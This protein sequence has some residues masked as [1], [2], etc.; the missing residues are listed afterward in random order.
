MFLRFKK[1]EA[2]DNVVDKPTLIVDNSYKIKLPL[3]FLVLLANDAKG[4]KLY[5]NKIRSNHNG[6]YLSPQKGRGMA[7]EEVRPYQAGDDVRSIDWKVTARTNTP[8]T[9][10]FREER[11]RPIF[12]SVDNSKTMQF[13]TRGVFKSVQAQ[14]LAALIA[15]AGYFHGDKIGGQLFTE[16]KCH[17][18]KP[19][20]GKHG[21]LQFLNVLTKTAPILEERCSF[22]RVILRLQ[23]HSKPGSLIYLLSDFRRLNS[24]SEAYL[25][26]LSRHCQVILIFILDPLEKKLPQSGTYEFTHKQK[27]VTI[28]AENKQKILSYEQRFENHQQNLKALAKKMNCALIICHTTDNPVDILR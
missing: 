8:H 4:I 23:R 18:I 15:W 26:K 24:T 1:K 9:K 25:A 20:N 12:I 2:V 10:I 13:A 14:K 22:E 28:S 19:Q 27:H 7:F 5:K 11:D 3:S 17:E 21:V 6:H 16:K